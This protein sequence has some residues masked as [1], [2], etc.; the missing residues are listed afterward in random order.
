MRT[1]ITDTT[2]KMAKVSHPVLC[3][4][5]NTFL[6][7]F[8]ILFTQASQIHQT[9][10]INRDKSGNNLTGHSYYN[11]FPFFKNINSVIPLVTKI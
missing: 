10:T 9:Q 7:V 5:Q 1:W 11:N 8:N 3:P 6:N 4:I 2:G